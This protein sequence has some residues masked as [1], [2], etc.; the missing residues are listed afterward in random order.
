MKAQIVDRTTI[1]RWSFGIVM[2]LALIL[3][4]H[5][6]AGTLQPD[7]IA[8]PSCEAIPL[9][10]SQKADANEE[11]EKIADGDFATKWTSEA[12]TFP[13]WVEIRWLQPRRGVIRQ[14]RATP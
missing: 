14:P 3:L 11:V 12:G 9:M 5:A 13:N 4:K 6:A 2:S 1:R 10:S 7:N 8:G